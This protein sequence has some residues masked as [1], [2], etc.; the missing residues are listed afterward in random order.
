MAP[1]GKYIGASSW[2]PISLS[3]L[4]V[5]SIYYGNAATCTTHRLGVRY[6]FALTSHT[7][8]ITILTLPSQNKP[9]TA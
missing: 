7:D 3:I 2:C 1:I 6:E 5:L 8:H 9:L 4:R